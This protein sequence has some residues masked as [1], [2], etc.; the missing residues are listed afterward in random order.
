M[1]TR[2]TSRRDFLVSSL[3]GVGA[4][5]VAANLGGI[6]AAEAYVQQAVRSGR[7]DALSGSRS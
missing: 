1:R 6:E 3:S 4:A 7:P 2:D 5:W